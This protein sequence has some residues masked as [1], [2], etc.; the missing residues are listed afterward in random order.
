MSRS[1]RI[2]EAKDLD[3][4]KRLLRILNEYTAKL[5]ATGV[6]RLFDLAVANGKKILPKDKNAL[7]V[8]DVI[9]NEKNVA[10]SVQKLLNLRF[11]CV[12]PVHLQPKTK[13]GRRHEV[14][15]W[16]RGGQIYDR[17]KDLIDWEAKGGTCFWSDM[18]G[19][20]VELIDLTQKD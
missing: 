10:D 2:L 6:D 9:L 19:D 1:K 15:F 18:N 4:F 3:L 20:K 11:G 16:S 7:A 13:K 14:A 8:L 12:Q 5:P 17:V